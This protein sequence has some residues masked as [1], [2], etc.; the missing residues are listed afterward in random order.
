MV[1]STA[2]N[3]LVTRLL[4]LGMLA[5]AIYVVVGELPRTAS[6]K[7]DATAGF[8]VGLVPVVLLAW[9]LVRSPLSQARLGLLVGLALVAGLLL[10]WAGWFGL[11]APF[12]V[13]GAV[14]LGYLLGLQLDRAWILVLIAVLAF[15]ADIWSVFAG[16]TR[17]IVE[18]APGV[19]D[20]ALVHFPALGTTEPG[21][22]LGM[23]DLVFLAL[24]TVGS[25]ANGL[26]PRISFAAMAVSL[27]VTF[28]ITLTTERA[29]PALPLL[30]VAFVMANADLLWRRLW[31]RLR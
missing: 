1:A 14:A 10:S 11:A 30:G 28:A 18:R 4:L 22:A 7:S 6:L 23:S 9:T 5:V 26:R 8:L 21:V 27:V 15:A 16:P 31:E 17:V 12:K 13:V 19:L 20:Y 3:G 24:F 25:G 29:L 2:R